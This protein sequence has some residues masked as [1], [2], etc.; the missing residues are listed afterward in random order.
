MYTW[1]CKY[2][3]KYEGNILNYFWEYEHSTNFS[4]I[5]ILFNPK[6]LVMAVFV[7]NHVT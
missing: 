1:C 3:K 2:I 7:L 5:K 4:S 6:K